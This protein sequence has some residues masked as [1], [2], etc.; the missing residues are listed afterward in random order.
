MYSEQDLKHAAEY[1]DEIHSEALTR[2]KAVHPNADHVVDKYPVDSYFQEI[3]DYPGKWYTVVGTPTGAGSRK[4]LVNSIVRETLE[5]YRNTGV[6]FSDEAFY[7]VIGEYPD[8][9]CDYCIVNADNQNAKEKSVFPYRGV[10]SHR[11][12][13]DCAARE[14]FDDGKEWSYDIKGAKCRKLSNKALFAPAGSDDWLN[15]RKAFLCPPHGNSYTDSDF[16]RIN[17]VLFPG[18]TEELDVYRWTTDWSD[19]FDEGH[20]WWGA[21]CITVYDKTLDR[22]VAIMASETD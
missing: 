19:Y 15:Y 1:R 10:D 12:A 8:I 22:F 6:A 13:L 20:E 5:Y 17:A 21:L 18:G 11:L 2:V 16:D 4:E 9:A 14:L 7:R 3:W